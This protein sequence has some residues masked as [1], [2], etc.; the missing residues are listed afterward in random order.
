MLD[1]IYV[2]P[3]GDEIIDNERKEDI[4]MHDGIEKYTHDDKSDA[5][6]IISPHGLILDKN[7]GVL[8]T[9]HLKSYYRTKTK[10]L[11]KE[12]ENDIKLAES[13]CDFEKCERVRY[14]TL[15]GNTFFNLDFGTV[16]P[17]SFFRIK[18]IVAIG[19]PRLLSREDV[20]KFA[21]HLYEV[22]NSSEKNVSVIISADQAHTHSPDGPYGFSD[23]ADI[24]DEKVRKA[25]NSGDFSEIEGLT[26]DF[27][28]KA[29]PDSFYNM[30]ILDSLLKN[31]GKRLN[32]EYYYVAKYFGMLFAHEV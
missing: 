6:V 5:I 11:R 3:H 8:Y 18:N 7:V 32:V 4:I 19:Q 26:D 2:I 14:T 20:K 9:R 31:S 1:H 21:Q 30:I 23:E 15:S 13:I 17:L 27:I 10:I 16:I 24:Y 29:K 28:E 22:I 25:I 12:Y